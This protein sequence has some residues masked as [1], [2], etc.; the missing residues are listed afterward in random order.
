MEAREG[1]EWYSLMEPIGLAFLG[2]FFSGVSQQQGTWA[3]KSPFTF[4]LAVGV[5]GEGVVEGPHD[6]I[7][8]LHVRDARVELGVDEEDPLHHLPVGLTAAGRHL[9]LTQGCRRRALVW[10]AHLG[11]E[12]KAC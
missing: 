4:P 10:G 8:A 3:A 1:H 5:G 2:P 12:G 6:L 7:H 9:V 11:R